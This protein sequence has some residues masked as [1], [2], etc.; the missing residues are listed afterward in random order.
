MR[1]SFSLA[2]VLALVSA[3]NQ[4]PAGPNILLITLD[5][6]R[7]DHLGAYGYALP[8]SPNLDR[9][10]A[11]GVVYSNAY[12]VSSWTMPTHASIFTGKYPSVHGATYDPKGPLNLGEGIG[13]RYGGYRARP[14]AENETTLAQVLSDAG[15]ATGGV[16]AGPWLLSR[17][18]LGKGFEHYDDS[19]VSALNGRPADDVT[20]AAIEFVDAHQSEPFFLFLNYFDAHSPWFEPPPLDADKK[21]TGPAKPFRDTSHVVPPGKMDYDLFANMCYDAEV[22]YMDNEIGR[23]LDHLK[24]RGLYEDTWIL[25]LSDHGELIGDKVLGDTGLYGHGDSLTEPEIH[26][27][28][29]VKEPGPARRKG[30]DPTFVQQVDVMPTILARLG[31]PRSADMQG[32]PFGGKHLV[33]AELHK[34]PF[35]NDDRKD[36]RHLGDWR[37]LVNGHDKYGWSSND[38]HFLIDLEADPQESTNRLKA[39]PEKVAKL[40]HAL[41]GTLKLW[42]KPGAVGEVAQPTEDDLEALQGLG[43]GGGGE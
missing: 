20:R 7:R 32:Q 25:V 1:P 14:I 41:Q 31:L 9:L 38:T 15:Y 3:C 21:P 24:L 30:V 6:T 43:Y 35:M 17:F 8:T 29:I 40:D 36:W 37:V 12:A 10:A 22:R 26:I 23:L 2:L 34:L 28:L 19:G 33:I 18:R 11:D 13:E 39:D 42:P 5:T 27:P 16:I 4:K